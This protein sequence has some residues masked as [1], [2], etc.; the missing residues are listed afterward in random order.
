MNGAGTN[1]FDTNRGRN[2]APKMREKQ[3]RQRQ[4]KEQR[5]AKK[6]Q[7]QRQSTLTPV[8][9]QQE[10]SQKLQNAGLD[11][12]MSVHWSV[13]VAIVIAFAGFF[14]LIN[15]RKKQKLKEQEEQT[16][17]IVSASRLDLANHID[18]VTNQLLPVHQVDVAQW[19]AKQQSNQEQN[20]NPSDSQSKVHADDDINRAIRR[21]H[22][23]KLLPKLQQFVRSGKLFSFVDSALNTPDKLKKRLT[24]RHARRHQSAGAATQNDQKTREAEQEMLL[25]RQLRARYGT[26]PLRNPFIDSQIKREIARL[27]ELGNQTPKTQTRRQNDQCSRPQQQNNDV[28]AIDDDIFAPPEQ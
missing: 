20:D 15:Q 24:E 27:K 2:A 26:D 10:A 25:E 12:L 14:I 19:H 9:R 21:K 7:R 16:R 11:I 18:P 22:S 1:N 8:D 3:A 17:H 13:I 28:T 23:Q 5:R 4:D 6:K